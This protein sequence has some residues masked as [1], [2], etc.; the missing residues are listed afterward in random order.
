[1][2]ENKTYNS[3]TFYF[4]AVVTILKYIYVIVSIT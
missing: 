1:M 4:M 3:Q 2:P